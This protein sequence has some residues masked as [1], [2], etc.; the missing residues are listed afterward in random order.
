MEGL[1]TEADLTETRVLK[2]IL[3]DR[4]TKN[5]PECRPFATYSLAEAL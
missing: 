5:G 4:K 2:C 3:R 1:G